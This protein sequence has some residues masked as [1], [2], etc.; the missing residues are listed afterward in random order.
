MLD[1]NLMDK[2][3]AL[4]AAGGML[5]LVVGLVLV[6]ACLAISVAICWFLMSCFQR[7]PPQFRKQ[8]PE[9]TWLLLIPCFN[10]IWNFFVFPKLSDSFKAYFDSIGR[11]DVGDC[12]RT[13]AMVNCILPIVQ[14][15][16]S[17]FGM[18]PTLAAGIGTLNCFLTLANLIVLILFL[19]KA[20]DLKNQIPAAT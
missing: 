8:Q 1:T 18:S 4:M 15:V 5:L 17:V 7:V 11:T 20:N 9:L 19:V 2:I 16:L 13:L 3:P 12:A 6:I 10:W 14:L